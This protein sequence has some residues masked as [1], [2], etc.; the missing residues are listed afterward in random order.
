[1]NRHSSFTFTTEAQTAV[2]GV[3][4]TD[5]G[6]TIVPFNMVPAYCDSKVVYTCTDITPASDLTCSLVSIN[7]ETGAV[8]LAFDP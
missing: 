5:V 4:Y 6:T 1:M 3:K 7:S 2:T 8:S